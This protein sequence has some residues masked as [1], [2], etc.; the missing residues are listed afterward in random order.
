MKKQE[1]ETLVEKSDDPLI[2]GLKKI[3]VWGVKVLAILM[4]PVIILAIVDVCVRIYQLLA[5]GGFATFH[6][7][8]LIDTLGA[9]LAV[10]IAVEVFLNI[11]FFLREN[12]VHVPLVLST[13][14]TAVARNVIL[15]DYA[16]E[17][18]HYIYASGAAIFSL[19][20]VY[21]LITKKSQ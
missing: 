12:A 7:A 18:P 3:V 4:V 11:V 1:E 5:M 17:D 15:I 9:F 13:A 16:G 10:L 19:G 20:L 2:E 21:W 8:G 14:L 6:V